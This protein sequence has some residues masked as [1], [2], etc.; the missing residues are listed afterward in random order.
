[1]FGLVGREAGQPGA[2]VSGPS[3]KAGRVAA[4]TGWGEPVAYLVLA[5]VFCRHLLADPAHRVTAGNPG[6]HALISYFLRAQPTALLHGHN[7]LLLTA[8]NAPDGVNMMWNTGLLL[9]SMLMAPIT[10]T[11]G[12]TFSFNVLLVVGL[13]GSAWSC[14]AVARRFTR[15]R[16]AAFLAGLVY[17]FSPAM[18]HQAIGHLHLVVAVLVPLLLAALLDVVTQA[19]RPAASLRLGALAAAQLLTGEELLACTVIAGAVVVAVL[20]ASR[21]RLCAARLAPSLRGLGLAAA[22]FGVLAFLPLAFQFLGPRH[23]YGSPFAF[24]VFKSDPTSFVTP[25]A[26][27]TL[28]SPAASRR[29]HPELN[30]YLGWP[31]LSLLAIVVAACRRDLRVRVAAL[32]GLV[33][34]VFSL[35]GTLIVA[36]RTTGVRLPWSYLQRMPLVDGL[37][38]NRFG[39]LVAGFAGFV[40]AMGVD[41]ALSANRTLARRFRHAVVWLPCCG[42]FLSLLPAPLQAAARPVPPDLI[43]SGHSQ[44]YL[45]TGSTV[46]VLPFPTPTDTTAMDWQADDGLRW[47]MPGGF[48]IGPD[49]PGRRCSGR[50]YLGESNTRTAR[51]LAGVGTGTAAPRPITR[52]DREQAAHDLRS[53]SV[54]RVLIGPGPRQQQLADA[55]TALLGRPGARVQDCW[56]WSLPVESVP[57]LRPVP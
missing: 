4:G 52:R 14:C 16:A 18:T 20:A 46:L 17:G 55:V 43:A 19:F 48:F 15:G 12:G 31:L 8:L 9:P 5:A 26:L 54:S 7:P 11:L 38:P 2:A 42:V 28:H 25:D 47:S 22:V 13:A 44:R 21:P 41:A 1:M 33:L 51:L 53:W 23:Q 45:P 32:T 57:G 50:A 3:Y 37:L 29:T 27:M 34:A 56:V 49:C 24:D 30:A 39:L 36:G 6:D 35:G 40:L 10:L